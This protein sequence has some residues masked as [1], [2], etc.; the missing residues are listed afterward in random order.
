MLYVPVPFC[1]LN[2]FKSYYRHIHFYCSS[3]CSNSKRF[4]IFAEMEPRSCAVE[5]LSPR[6]GHSK[7]YELLAVTSP[8]NFKHTIL[9][10]PT[11]L[12]MMKSMQ[13]LR[14]EALFLSSS[15]ASVNPTRDDLESEHEA[16]C[17]LACWVTPATKPCSWKVPIHY[18]RI[19]ASKY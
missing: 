19:P 8:S 4:L 10:A 5:L 17:S 12:E 9:E 18:S 7:M 6:P 15:L 2:S 1:K 16:A 11:L 13:T 14:S 3:F